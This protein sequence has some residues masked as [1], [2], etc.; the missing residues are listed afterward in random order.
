MPPDVRNSNAVIAVS[1]AV[2]EQ[3]VGATTEVIYPGVDLPKQ[4]GRGH[5]HAG[6]VVGVASRLVR[7]KG[8]HH[9]L[10]A[11]AALRTE[12]SNVRLEIAGAGPELEALRAQAQ[13]LGIAD[14]ITF[15]GWQTEMTETLKRWDVLAHPSL[16]EGFPLSVL[17]AM[18][19]G[20][21]V[22]ATDVGGTSELVE[23]GSTGWL[24]PGGK[25][26]ALAGRLRALLLS[27]ERS[28]GMGTA[29]RER[30]RDRFSARK[31]S[32]RIARIYDKILERTA[33]DLDG[34]AAP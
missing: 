8:L 30:V 24:V 14:C 27:P 25:P 12:L 15:L 13:E 23:H 6:R 22:V 33:Q 32:E 16:E 5:Q 21:P 1:R 29:A 34:E 20:L 18:A 9:L 10:H 17:E 31:M 11:L 7:A 2:A 4:T 19:A 26:S 3:V 28:Q